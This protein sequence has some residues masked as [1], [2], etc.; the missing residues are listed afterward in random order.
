MSPDQRS[1]LFREVNERIYDLLES[2]DPDLPGEFFCECGSDCGRRVELLPAAFVTL[3]ETGE[4][5][6]S[7]DCRPPGLRQRGRRA[8]PAGGVPA[9]G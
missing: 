3:R 6:R 2:A 5:L 8:R 1:L 4:V 9:L 7:P